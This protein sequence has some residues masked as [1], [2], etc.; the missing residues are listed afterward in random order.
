MFFKKNLF[1]KKNDP[2]LHDDPKK[3]AHVKMGHRDPL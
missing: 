1:K 3:L 2:Q